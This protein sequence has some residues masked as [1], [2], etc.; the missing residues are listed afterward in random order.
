V[1]DVIMQYITWRIDN[2][3]KVFMIIIIY[4]LMLDFNDKSRHAHTKKYKLLHL[5]GATTHAF[6]LF[7]F[8]LCYMILDSKNLF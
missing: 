3:P 6:A 5:L 7:V 2:A 4:L 8:P 1:T